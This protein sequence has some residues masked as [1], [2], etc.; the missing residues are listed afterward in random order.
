MS[1]VVD[2]G[3]GPHQVPDQRARQGET[4]QPKQKKNLRVLLLLSNGRIPRRAITIA[5]VRT[6]THRRQR[7]VLRAMRKNDFRSCACR[8]SLTTCCR[9][10]ASARSMKHSAERAELVP[11]GGSRGRRHMLQTSKPSPTV[12]THCYFFEVIQLPRQAAA[13]VKATSKLCL[14]R[15]SSEQET[16]C[17]L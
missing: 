1:K 9:D 5:N 3:P 6:D 13:S 7:A 16:A 8:R 4:P 15:S 12:P 2:N 17:D 14:K 10:S 11:S